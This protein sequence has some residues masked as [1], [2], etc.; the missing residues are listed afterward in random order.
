MGAQSEFIKATILK[1]FMFKSLSNEALMY[2]IN[3]FEGPH[4]FASQTVIIQQ[5]D[6]L[7]DS[8]PGIYVLEKGT[9]D[10]LRKINGYDQ[11]ICNVSAG[12]CQGQC[13]G[14]RA[15]LNSSRRT[16]TIITSSDAILWWLRRDVFDRHVKGT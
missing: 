9:I 5:G 14:H 12:G 4:P 1:S 13:F 2:V 11:V 8:D 3:S 7:K 15:L 16:E 10:L 6:E